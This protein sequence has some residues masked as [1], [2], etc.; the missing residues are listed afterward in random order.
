MQWLHH[1]YHVDGDSDNSDN[2]DVRNAAAAG[3]SVHSHNMGRGNRVLEKAMKWMKYD[4]ATTAMSTTTLL[5]QDREKSLKRRSEDYY[6]FKH[7]R[8]GMCTE[9]E[10]VTSFLDLGLEV[11]VG[12]MR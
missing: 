7:M 1:H 5:S 6:S 10:N 3:S 11:G 2:K 4:I 8:T 9:I 12:V